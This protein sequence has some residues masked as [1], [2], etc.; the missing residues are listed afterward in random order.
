MAS[1]F[2]PC[3]TTDR[4]K[5]FVINLCSEQ[6]GDIM[7]PQTNSGIGS[8]DEKNSNNR[9]DQEAQQ[10]I[11]E[12][13]SQDVQRRIKSVW[14]SPKGKDALLVVTEFTIHSSGEITDIRLLES[15][16]LPAE[17]KT[18]LE[19]IKNSSPLP[20]LPDG[21]PPSL[22]MQFSFSYSFCSDR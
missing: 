6:A 2:Q 18:A 19:A 15:S 9:D 8:M 16:G 1:S 17:D 13:Y 22:V 21:M 11:F 4:D 20:P 7:L 10:K 3:R 5:S 14:V 12:L